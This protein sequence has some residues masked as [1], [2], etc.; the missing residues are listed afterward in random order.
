MPSDEALRAADVLVDGDTLWQAELRLRQSLW[1]ERLG[2]PAGT[3]GNR[4]LGSRLPAGD[5]TS[6]FLTPTVAD[7]VEDARRQ[8]GALVS[9]PRIYENMLSSQPLAFNLFAEVAASSSLRSAVGRALWPDLFGAVYDVRFEW[10]PGRGDTAFLGN[11]SA[12]DVVLTGRDPAGQ[13]TVVGVEVKYHENLTQDPGNPGNPR[14]GE[15]AAAAGVFRD[16]EAEDLRALP[17][18]QV[19]FDHL[20]A[21]MVGADVDRARFVLLAPATN[22]AATAV[23]V[24]YRAQL[25]NALSYE[26]RTLEEVAA[27]VRQHSGPGWADDFTARYLV[28]TPP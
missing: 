1:R 4:K 20:L 13:R 21:L 3:L 18:R 16:P 14:Y 5:R 11:R 25:S 15:V 2:V 22:P 9:A 17:L 12:F 8:P 19:W 10:S 24:A 23:D 27:V 28:P 26:R 6:N 7:A